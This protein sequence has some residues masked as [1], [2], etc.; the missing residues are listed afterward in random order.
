MS[1]LNQL[2]NIEIEQAGLRRQPSMIEERLDRL[3][4]FSGVLIEAAQSSA[5]SADYLDNVVAQFVSDLNAVARFGNNA[6]RM[7]M[8][9]RGLRQNAM[10]D[11]EML[12]NQIAGLKE[13]VQHLQTNRSVDIE[14][15][16]EKAVAKLAAAYDADPAELMAALNEQATDE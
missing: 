15:A 1:R 16:I 3:Q 2:V 12:V 7:V 9:E 8:E 11:H 14:A 6:A 4:A 10:A 13:L 5:M